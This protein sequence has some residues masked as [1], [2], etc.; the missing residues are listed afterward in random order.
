MKKHI[1]FCVFDTFVSFYLREEGGE[2][3]ASGV[4]HHNGTVKSAKRVCEYIQ[5]I[6][7]FDTMEIIFS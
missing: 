3:Q 4:Q 5:S 7:K 2:L 6:L 1:T